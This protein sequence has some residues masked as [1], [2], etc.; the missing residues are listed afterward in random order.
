MFFLFLSGHPDL[1]SN[2]KIINGSVK[3]EWT[4]GGKRNAN[5]HNIMYIVL[6]APNIWYNIC[7]KGGLRMN[8]KVTLYLSEKIRFTLEAIAEAEGRNISEIIRE[9]IILLIK[10][11]GLYNP[12]G[13]KA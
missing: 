7:M 8:K 6:F 2:G 11:R 4:V 3:N 5:R 10:D 12:S 13:V 9:A 1:P